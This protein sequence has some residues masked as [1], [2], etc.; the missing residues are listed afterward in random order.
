MC[1]TMNVLCFATDK[2]LFLVCFVCLFCF[3]L[4]CFVLFLPSSNPGC[5]VYKSVGS[6]KLLGAQDFLTLKYVHTQVAALHQNYHV[7]SCSSLWLQW[8][9][10]K[11]SRSQ[12][13]LWI[14]C[15][16]KFGA[17]SLASKLMSLVKGNLL[18]LRFS[19]FLLF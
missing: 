15:I 9:Q 7:M 13:W 5:I 11:V 16:S 12:L 3:V 14:H 2:S 17:G 6:L 18:I 1:S 4:F 10:L 19:S 8:H